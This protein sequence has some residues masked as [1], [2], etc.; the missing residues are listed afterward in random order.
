MN[1]VLLQEQLKLQ[2]IDL[3]LKE[4]PQYLFLSL[5]ESAYKKLS[6]DDWARVEI[7]YGSRL[8]PEE[9]R[10]AHQLRWIHCPGPHL[11]RLCIDEIEKQG[12]V[13]VTNTADEN[14]G[15]IGEFVFSGVLAFAKNLFWWKEENREPAL[16]WDSQWRESMWTLKDKVL[17]Q[18]GLG[19]VGGEIARRGR[20]FDMKVWGV[21][22]RK[23]F[24]PE[25][26]KTFNFKDLHSILP[27][28]D[29][30]SLALPRGR[31]YAHL[32]G[33]DEFDL[34]KPGSILSIVGASTLVDAEALQ[35]AAA[36]GKFRG[37]LLDA[38]FQTPILAAS[39]LWKIPNILITPEVSP[40]PK[41]TDRLSFRAF[42][43]NLRQYLHGNF[44]DM[45]NLVEL[46]PLITA[47]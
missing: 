37:I 10:K 5:S 36:E 27:A 19:R 13:L 8:N 21:Q 45:R 18:I 32:L 4:F 20:Q 41:S 38:F 43:Y 23:S 29:V 47:N 24:H 16:V 15:Q 42:L 12:N 40:R 7:I 22:Q 3:L 25:C 11:N 34:I 33:K 9:L 6:A 1:I 14:V 35:I 46:L 39:P 44:K 26:H 28:V 17:L 2:E 30:I 31:E